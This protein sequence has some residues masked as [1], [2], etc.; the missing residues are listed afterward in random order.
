MDCW[1]GSNGEP[2]IYHGGTLTS[3]VL[4]VDVCE[5]IK[6][7]AFVASE[8][9]YRAAVVCLCLP[10]SLTLVLSLAQLSGDLVAREPLRYRTSTP[11]G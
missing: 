3:Q 9:V 8:Y 6:K 5:T 4:F 10:H 2:I 11:H 7:F 1:N